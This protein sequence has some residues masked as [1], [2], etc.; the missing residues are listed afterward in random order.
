MSKE[1]LREVANASTQALLTLLAVEPSYPRRMGALLG[2]SETE[3]AR[4]LKRLE[5]LG[6]VEG[7]WERQGKN[8]K[9]Y[10]LAADLV[11]IGITPSGLSVQV[12]KAQARAARAPTPIPI[13]DDAGFVGR[14]GELARLAGP[15][16][17]VLVLGMPGIG[18]T[19]LLARYARSQPEGRPV[20]WR[21][22]R[23]VES[24]AWLANQVALHLAQ[25]GDSS[26]MERLG[27]DPAQLADATIAAIDAHAGIVI[28]DEAH[29]AED[30]AVRNLLAD[31]VARV[32]HGK[33]VIASR[34][35]IGHNPAT[36]GLAVLHLSGLPD[37]DAA[38]VLESRGLTVDAALYGKL[39]AEVGGHPLGLQLLAQAAQQAG[40]LESLLD[41]IPE[42]DLE[43][44][45]LQELH[46]GLSDDERLA[47]S[48]AS[49]LRPG[50]GAAD[51]AAVSRRR[52]DA[53]LATLRRRM[54]VSEARG[55]FQ[56]HE[57]V[58]N[59]FYSRLEDKATLHGRAAAHYVAKGTV[60]GRL[61][62]MHHFV[63]AGQRPKVLELLRQNLDLRDFDFVDAGYQALYLGILGL[64]PQSEVRERHLWGLIQDEK[65]DIALHNGKP[66]V[67]LPLYEEA[68]A[69]FRDAV[70]PARCADAAWK[71]ALCLERLGRHDEADQA[72]ASALDAAPRDGPERG[73]L[74]ELLA[75]LR[76]QP[77][78][79][80]AVDIESKGSVNPL[81]E[82]AGM[83]VAGPT[84]KTKAPRRATA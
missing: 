80:V 29:R 79:E 67:A 30:P 44:W 68:L 56:L 35:W 15:E 16:P 50:F 72:C 37:A 7:R 21:S 18:K 42:R 14:Q 40:S 6:L 12:G 71:R 19:S 74:V 5:S 55:T 2:L 20:F 58:Q 9:L 34:E 66:A 23:G 69:A 46:D 77:V 10:R 62:A 26:L 83:R 76:G 48:H 52:L 82:P 28:L 64:F 32:R 3:V 27:A 75:T 38:A 8:V 73:R 59:F 45:L 53:V 70:E 63:A 65:A 84:G 78:A 4:R 33:L 13:P 41:R 61:E 11:T 51:L 25:Y 17:V 31:A 36:P 54:L 60:E 22:L 49:L 81:G 47:L 43:T 57:V 1:V 24:V 39:R